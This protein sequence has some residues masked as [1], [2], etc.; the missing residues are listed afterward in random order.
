M[1]SNTKELKEKTKLQAQTQARNN[2]IK[3]SKNNGMNNNKKNENITKI[4]T[5]LIEKP[6]FEIINCENPDDKI[7]MYGSIIRFNDNEIINNN[8]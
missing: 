8:K 4:E 2:I 5:Q 3:K 7:N 6:S 1:S